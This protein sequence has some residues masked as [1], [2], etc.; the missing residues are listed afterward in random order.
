MEL[1]RR[2]SA[3]K[4]VGQVGTPALVLDGEQAFQITGIRECVVILLVSK[5]GLAHQGFKTL[6]LD[7]LRRSSPRVRTWP[8]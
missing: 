1:T 3:V 7:S 8:G 2:F 5:T 6:A 4:Q